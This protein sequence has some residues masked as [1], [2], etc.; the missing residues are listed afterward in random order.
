MTFRVRYN[1]DLRG[2]VIQSR[3]T[4]SRQ[5][6]LPR[7]SSRYARDGWRVKARF[8]E[9]H[10][11]RINET[12]E[13]RGPAIDEAV[14]R[15]IR[16]TRAHIV[17]SALKS[18]EKMT[19]TVIDGDFP[20]EVLAR[21]NLTFAE[22]HM[23]LE[24]SNRKYYDANKL[25]RVEPVSGNLY[26]GQLAALDDPTNAGPAAN[27]VAP[28]PPQQSRATWFSLIVAV[29][30]TGAIAAWRLPGH[31]RA[32]GVAAMLLVIV[33]T[34]LV[35]VGD[36]NE[37]IPSLNVLVR[38]LGN[39]DTAELASQQIA[40]LG[41]RAVPA[42]IKQSRSPN[43]VTQGWALVSLGRIGGKDAMRQL[44]SIH[45]HE[46]VSPLVQTWAAAAMVHA[47]E[48]TEE[49]EELSQLVTGRPELSRSFLIAFR[50]LLR[51]EAGGETVQS[52]LAL[53]SRIPV[54]KQG[55]ADAMAAESAQSLFNEHLQ[56]RTMHSL[57]GLA[58][59]YPQLAT[60][61]AMEVCERIESSSGVDRFE[62]RLVAA[63]RSSTLAT[64]LSRDVL[65]DG[66][67]PLIHAMF[68][69]EDLDVRRTA[70]GYLATLGQSPDV[71][72]SI[73][74]EIV[75]A[76]EFT[77]SAKQTPWEGGALFIPNIP[78]QDQGAQD[79]VD[80]LMRWQLWAARNEDAETQQ[81]IRINL[82]SV[83]LA[84]A[85]KYQVAAYSS[86]TAWLKSWKQVVG[87]KAMRE[88]LAEQAAEEKYAEVLLD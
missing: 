40:T 69:A 77:P 43:L 32:V 20:R 25:G 7:T 23:P 48:T 42:M 51:E 45:A 36:E 80:N 75:A 19:M 6:C 18:I 5:S 33:S 87:A 49:L 16:S 66:A 47:A 41:D 46:S 71:S 13:L 17:H 31:R 22:Y 84:S 8:Y 37:S 4:A 86:T 70:A 73:S 76:L 64:A 39:P 62:A 54:L 61:I 74:S 12:L 60:P 24:R 68:R 3:I 81:Q 50:R 15:Q 83:S 28:S 59:E 29:V 72:P 34:S 57:V 85:A 2:G 9:K 11:F 21:E 82:N 55:V 65:A 53:G 79:L 38:R 52:L 27:E 88:L 56:S 26:V 44:A 58:S 14:R 10:L 1:L 35:A 78:W 67:K 30:L 63:S